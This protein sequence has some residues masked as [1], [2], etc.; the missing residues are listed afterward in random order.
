[1]KNFLF[2]L[3]ISLDNIFDPENRDP[4]NVDARRTFLNHETNANDFNEVVPRHIDRHSLRLRLDANKRYLKF[5]KLVRQYGFDNIELY[6]IDTI[7]FDYIEKHIDSSARGTGAEGPKS[8]N[9][10]YMSCNDSLTMDFVERHMDKPWDWKRMTYNESLTM[11]FVERHM[12]LPW[13]LCEL[14]KNPK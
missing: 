11:D 14:S 5:D 10:S 1:M 3:L 6:D 13:D 9:W 4:V 12:D 7:Y 2:N 8:W